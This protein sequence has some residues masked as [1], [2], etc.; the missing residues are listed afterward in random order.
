M[1]RLS[2]CL[3]SDTAG[4]S[5]A[6]LGGI[7]IFPFVSRVLNPILIGSFGQTRQPRFLN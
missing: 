2:W 6:C 5:L 1:V 4:M 7:G 3:V